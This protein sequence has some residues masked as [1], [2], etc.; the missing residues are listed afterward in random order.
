MH[1]MYGPNILRVYG[2]LSLYKLSTVSM[3]PIESEDKWTYFKG[4]I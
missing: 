3:H 4:C 2:M 1:R